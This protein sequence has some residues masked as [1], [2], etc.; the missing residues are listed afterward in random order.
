MSFFKFLGGRLV[1]LVGLVRCVRDAP[2]LLFVIVLVQYWSM[3]KIFS[4]SQRVSMIWAFHDFF[5]LPFCCAESIAIYCSLVCHRVPW[6]CPSA[7]LVSFIL[8]LGGLV[9]W[10]LCLLVRPSQTRS[11]SFEHPHPCTK[12]YTVEHC[13]S[14]PA[15]K[16]CLSIRHKNWHV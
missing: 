16:A 9:S 12:L 8:C 3:Q 13:C 11:S 2:K 1:G 15:K 4:L 10:C 7:L 5:G 6:P 14:A